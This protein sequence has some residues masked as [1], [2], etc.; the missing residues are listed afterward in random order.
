MQNEKGQ[1]KGKRSP[2]KNARSK[3]RN[4]ARKEKNIARD[5][6]IQEDTKVA[7]L[8]VYASHPFTNGW[9]NGLRIFSDLYFSSK[10]KFFELWGRPLVDD[11][12]LIRVQ[13][14]KDF[15]D[16]DYIPNDY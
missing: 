8:Y 14:T 16:W 3:A 13:V 10:D 5:L 6:K 4:K 11:E 2:E 12:A 9:R 7:W 1:I 15:N